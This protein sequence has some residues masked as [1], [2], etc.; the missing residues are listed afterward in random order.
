VL[1]EFLAYL[2]KLKASNPGKK[3]VILTYRQEIFLFTFSLNKNPSCL[4]F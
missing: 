3:I 4:G 1:K 2:T